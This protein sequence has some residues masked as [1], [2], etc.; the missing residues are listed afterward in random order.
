LGG[1]GQIT[2][3]GGTF[4]AGQN[5]GLG[6]AIPVSGQVL[7]RQ[8]SDATAP[9]SNVD[10]LYVDAPFCEDLYKYVEV[11]GGGIGN[12]IWTGGRQMDGFRVGF[13]TSNAPAGSR[14]QSWQITGVQFNSGYEIDTRPAPAPAG[15]GRPILWVRPPGGTAN[16]LVVNGCSFGN[17]PLGPRIG[18]GA[19]AALTGNVFRNYSTAPIIEFAGKGAVNGNVSFNPDGDIPAFGIQWQ[20]GPQTADRVAAGNMFLGATAQESTGGT[21]AR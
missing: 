19:S 20:S 10:G 6:A 21:N 18:P 15:L 17:N 3:S 13:D 14:N 1:A 9:S 7:V 11:L 16:G 4:N 8:T 12:L 2:I 5:L